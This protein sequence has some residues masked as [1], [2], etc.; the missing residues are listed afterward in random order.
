[1]APISV[2]SSSAVVDKAVTSPNVAFTDKKW[3]KV[4]TWT[5][6]NLLASNV[7]LEDAMR[8]D[9]GVPHTKEKRQ[10]TKKGNRKAMGGVNDWDCAYSSLKMS[11]KGA[12]PAA[13]GNN[14][15]DCSYRLKPCTFRSTISA[16][17]STSTLLSDAEGSHSRQSSDEGLE[18]EETVLEEL[19]FEQDECGD[20][21]RHVFDIVRIIGSGSYGTVLLCRLR[22]CPNRLYAVKVVY[23]SKLSDREGNSDTTRQVQ[24]LLTEKNILCSVTHPFITKMYCSF[25]TPDA[26]N[27]VLE[28]CPGGDMYFLLEKFPHKRLPE[29][30][31][32]FYAAS[33][34]LAL[35]YLHHRGIMYRDLKPENILLD[36]AGFLRLADFGLA[37]EHMN[38]SEQNCTSFCG[39]AD[40]IAPEVIRGNGYGLAADLWSFGCVVYE[41]LTG[42]PPFYSHHDRALLFD[43]IKT[44][45]PGFPRH[46]SP[47]LCDFLSGLLHKESS[48]RLGNGPNGMQEIFDHPF[49]ANISWHRLKTKQVVPPLVPN[50]AGKLDT[51][52]FENQF[53]SQLVD[54][55]LVYEER[56][57]HRACA[58]TDENSFYF[59]EFDWCAG[60]S[61][62]QENDTI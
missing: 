55:H 25:E 12:E 10:L 6:A 53:T 4:K 20:G 18:H 17:S 1:M 42:F 29:D 43:K 36:E 32:Q 27:Y 28:Y 13:A 48:Q 16:S 34:A 5:F 23:K 2:P 30:H 59:G 37:H 49:F 3:A 8:N 58:G 52:N 57:S 19:E 40:Y 9:D 11:P 44:D 54:G 15:W 14:D 31:V 56:G 61:H 22:A 47:P 35:R 46:C 7:S 39:S 33:I 38:P 21:T 51:S 24:R 50:L 45:E 62:F 26:L 60:A 41:M